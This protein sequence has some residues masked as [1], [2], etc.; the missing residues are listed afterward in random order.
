MRVRSLIMGIVAW[1]LGVAIP[2][3]YSACIAHAAVK[4]E[5]YA[6]PIRDLMKNFN[7]MP[8]LMW[9]YVIA[10]GVLGLLMVGHGLTRPRLEEELSL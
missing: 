5:G 4:E 6:Y 10:M 1:T 8:L 2:A 3:M 7:S 9:L